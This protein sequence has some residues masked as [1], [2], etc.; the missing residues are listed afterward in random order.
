MLLQLFNRFRFRQRGKLML[1]FIQQD[2]I[3][4]YPVDKR[5]PAVYRREQLRDTIPHEVAE[6]PYCMKL[7]PGIR[8]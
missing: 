4:R 3:H 5:C 6:C 8:D 7:W 1:Y 2:T